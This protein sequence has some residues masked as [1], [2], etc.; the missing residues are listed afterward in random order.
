M[1]KLILALTQHTISILTFRHDGTGLPS[2]K[3]GT[4]GLIAVLAFS[5]SLMHSA[6]LGSSLVEAGLFSAVAISFVALLIRPTPGSALLLGGIGV[7]LMQCLLYGIA[8]PAEP[9]TY[10]GL[11]GLLWKL[12][13]F[14]AVL[15]K[16]VRI[17]KQAAPKTN[18]ENNKEGH[19]K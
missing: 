14:A 13:A 16:M 19:P 12:A 9:P 4:H 5:V 17:L 2:K 10:M 18:P 11:A 7:E 1:S 15:N 8:A 6:L 3:N